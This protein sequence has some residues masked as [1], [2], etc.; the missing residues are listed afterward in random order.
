MGMSLARKYSGGNLITG[1]F[2]ASFV[3]VAMDGVVGV[4]SFIDAGSVVVDEEDEPP[5]PPPE[6]DDDDEEAVVLV[7]ALL[8]DML[9]S[10][11]GL[12]VAVSCCSVFMLRFVLFGDM[13]SPLT[14]ACD[15]E[16]DEEEFGSAFI[17]RVVS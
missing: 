14:I 5:P 3:V 2:L 10:A 7:P 12:S 11:A 13:S 6:E 4:G 16:V 17:V 15:V 8:G 1:L 9:D